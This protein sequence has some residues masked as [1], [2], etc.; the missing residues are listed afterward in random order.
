MVLLA[1]DVTR[2]EEAIVIARRA[3]RIARQSIVWGLGLSAAAMVIAAGSVMN[4]PSTGAMI[5][6][7]SHQAPGVP[8]PIAATRRII[9]DTIRPSHR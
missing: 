6:V 9:D 8:R 3:V 1:D 7:A 2:T 4:E 5:S